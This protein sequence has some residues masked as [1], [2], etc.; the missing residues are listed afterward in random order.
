MCEPSLVPGMPNDRIL[1]AT[2][3]MGIGRVAA[4]QD[5]G[6]RQPRIADAS[7]L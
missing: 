5:V 7:I 4:L 3:G 1:H 2:H 6:R